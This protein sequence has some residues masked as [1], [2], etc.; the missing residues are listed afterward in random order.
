MP[1]DQWH[2]H[3]K[4]KKNG[5]KPDHNWR[6]PARCSSRSEVA[7]G[8]GKVKDGDKDFVMDSDEHT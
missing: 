5:K 8:S 7:S 1:K 3:I 4:N 2:E 6:T